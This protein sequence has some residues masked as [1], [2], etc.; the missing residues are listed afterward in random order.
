MKRFLRFT[1]FITAILALVGCSSPTEDASKAVEAIDS[2]KE[3]IVSALNEVVALESNVQ[4]DMESDLA[5]DSGEALSSGE[6]NI[7]TN[8][9]ERGEKIE[10][11]AKANEAMQEGNDQ[12]ASATSSEETEGLPMTELEHLQEQVESL[13]THVESYVDQYQGEL[14]AEER[15]FTELGGENADFEFLANG[16]ESINESHQETTKAMQDIHAD[17][18]ASIATLTEVKSSLPTDAE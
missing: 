2:Q 7:F 18:E 9:A 11:L 10:E 12:L 5:E 17:L 4:E 1:G 8:V 6:A 14:E 15:F 3:T 16:I 13:Q